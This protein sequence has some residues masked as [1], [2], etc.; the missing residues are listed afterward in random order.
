MIL[1]DIDHFKRVNDTH[2]HH[3]GDL[4]LKEVAEVLRESTRGDDLVA[5]Y[6]GEEFILALPICSLVQA[7]ER[8]EHIRTRLS[9]RLVE[10]SDGHVGV[11]A[12]LGLSFAPAGRV[13]DVSCADHCGRQGA[14]RSQASRA[15]PGDLLDGIAPG[16]HS[17]D[18]I[19]RCL[20]VVLS[21]MVRARQR[22]LA[23]C[24][25]AGYDRADRHFGATE[26]C[27]SSLARNH[28]MPQSSSTSGPV[29][30]PLSLGVCSWSLQVRSVAELRR[31][32]DD[33]GINVVQIACGDP[34][35]A[36]WDE[37]DAFPEAAKLGN[38]H[39]RG[40]AGFSGRGLHH[41]AND[42]GDRRLRQPRHTSRTP[43]A[44]G[45]GTRANQG[46]GLADLTLHAGF[47]P[48]PGDPDRSAM[49]DTLA[50]AAELARKSGVT[51]AFETGQETAEL[52]HTTLH[53]LRATNL[54]INFDPAN[55]LL[56]DMG[57]P[58]KAVELLGA[59]IR[60]VH[61][62]D[63]RRPR[64]PGQWGEEVPLGEGEV[65]I[66]RFIKALKSIGYQGPLVI[67]R[68]V[69]DQAGRL[70]DVAHGLKFLRECLAV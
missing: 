64:T 24:S 52:L 15:K 17:Q 23:S 54:K 60:S 63:A 68:E 11:T 20:R 40:H 29:L 47:L 7:K 4:I 14:L 41:A 39:D 18:R 9:S 35:H 51:L 32:L 10:V 45:V 22:A 55:M 12:S 37:E 69:G 44:A 59:N 3:V 43:E 34:H 2:G 53:E 61:V 21:R 26:I 66:P 1:V 19:C 25:L 65:D 67:E 28:S 6:G 48:Q 27:S 13:R 58:I 38:C 57:D 42:Q 31:L 62:K 70:R 33:L 49:L 8:A 56:Y 50:Q 30:S 36:S 5:R 46:A 16:I